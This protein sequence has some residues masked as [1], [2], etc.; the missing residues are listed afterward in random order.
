MLVDIAVGVVAERVVDTDF[1][2]GTLDAVFVTAAAIPDLFVECWDQQMLPVVCKR[3]LV[4]LLA[5]SRNM[6]KILP[7]F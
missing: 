2:V 3:M 5:D 4:L 7:L 6:Y 1:L